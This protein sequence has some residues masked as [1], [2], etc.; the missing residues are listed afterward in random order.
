MDLLYFVYQSNQSKK[1]KK[2]DN[3]TIF[4]KVLMIKYGLK[5]E[6]CQYLDI[7]GHLKNLIFSL[8]SQYNKDRM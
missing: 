8:L 7:K 4:I 1:N 6:K 2:I 5:S 3:R